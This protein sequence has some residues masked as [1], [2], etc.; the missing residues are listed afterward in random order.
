MIWAAVSLCEALLVQVN[1]RPVTGYLAD[2]VL[3]RR[4]HSK[5]TFSFQTPTPS[6]G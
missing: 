1:K 2:L 5:P 4:G 6:A 3:F